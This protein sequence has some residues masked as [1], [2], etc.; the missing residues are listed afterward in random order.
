VAL[1]PTEIVG[2]LESALA[3]FADRLERQKIELVRALVSR[4]APASCTR[5][6]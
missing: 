6:S 4:P 3:L 5:C 1:E 2:E